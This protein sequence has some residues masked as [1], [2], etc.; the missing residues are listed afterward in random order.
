MLQ[1]VQLQFCEQERAFSVRLYRGRNGK[2]GKFYWLGMSIEKRGD[3]RMGIPVLIL[4][5]SGSGKSASMRNFS[6]DYLGIIN[7]SGKPLPFRGNFKMAMTD[8]LS[9]GHSGSFGQQSKIDR[10]R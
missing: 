10:D 4:G 8:E 1:V 6:P 7:V 9:K 2:P 3:Q 5:E